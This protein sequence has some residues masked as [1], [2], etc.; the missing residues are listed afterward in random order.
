VGK[1]VAAPEELFATAGLR[2]ISITLLLDVDSDEL[3]KN[4]SRGFEDNSQKSEISKFRPDL[5]RMR[6]IFADQ[7]N[8]GR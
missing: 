3:G 2:R 5:I 7:K 8:A 1:E 6:Q 4:F